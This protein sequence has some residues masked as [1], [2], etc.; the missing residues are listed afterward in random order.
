MLIFIN[1]FCRSYISFD[2]LRR[3]L[4]N[5]FGYNVL[6]VMNITDIDDKIIKRARQRY[7][8]EQYLSENNNL[9]QIVS[10]TKEVM[11]VFEQMVKR[12]TDPDK[13][14]LYEKTLTNLNASV[15]KLEKAVKE[16]NQEDIK[17]FQEVIMPS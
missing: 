5:Y 15:E 8:Y 3:V 17:Q 13:K 6:Y 9:E 2:I 14:Q 10:D 11:G 4:T 16:N 7:L 1:L 12:A